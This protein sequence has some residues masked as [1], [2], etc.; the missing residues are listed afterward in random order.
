M[1]APLLD[2]YLAGLAARLME[3]RGLTEALSGSLSAEDQTVQS[4]PDTSPTKWHRGHTTWFFETFVLGPHR[5]RHRVYDPHYNYLFNSYYEAVGDRYPRADRGKVTRPGAAEIGRYRA[6]VD[7]TLLSFLAELDPGSVADEV[8][9]LVELGINH[10]QQHQELLLMDIKHVLANNTV[11]AAYDQR[12]HAAGA[13][14]GPLDWCPF[15]GGVVEI[16]TGADGFAFDNEGPR[17]ETLLQPFALGDRLVTC[18]EWLQFMADGGYDEPRWW[19]SD[20][21][22][23]RGAEG[24]EAPLYWTGERD[25]WWVHT[26]TGRRPVDPAEPVCHV[27]FYEADAYASWAG[28]RLPT[29]A[30]WELAARSVGG[31][32]DRG[33]LRYRGLDGAAIVAGNDLHPTP[34]GSPSTDP[35]PRPRQLF[36]DCWEW[37]GSAYRPYPGFRSPE[38][39]IGEYNGKFMINTMVLRGGSALTPADHVRATYRNFFHPHTRWHLSGMRLATD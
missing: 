27:S 5:P 6:A 18:G 36:G 2:Q 34:A 20:G 4:M 32:G 23:T 17:H 12:P 14:P 9:A 22:H 39:A 13:D 16:G 24:W 29:E 21:W 7:E 19:L 15:E 31:T 28:A 35:T 37:T 1:T 25:R 38:G 8:A 10:E 26:L 33:L 30:E 3:V 11:D